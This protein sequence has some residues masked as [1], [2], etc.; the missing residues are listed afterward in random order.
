MTPMPAPIR[1]AGD[2][3]RR[4]GLRSARRKDGDGDGV[5][6]DKDRC[7]ST[8]S[9]VEVDAEGCQVLF[10]PTKKTL[11]LEGVNFETGKS[12]LTPESEAILN[13]VAESLVANDSIR[14]QVTGHTDNTGSLATQPAAL[15]RPGRRG[16]DLPHL[17]GRG[18]G[19][20][21]GPRLRPGPADR[22]QQDV[23]GQGAEPAGGV[24]QAQLDIGDRYQR[25]K[26]KEKGSAGTSK[27]RVPPFPSR[28]A[29]A[30][31]LFLAYSPFGILVPAGRQPLLRRGQLLGGDLRVLLFQVLRPVHPDQLEEVGDRQRPDEQAEQAEVAQAQERADDGDERMDLGPA[32]EDDRPDH[33]VHVATTIRMPQSASPIAAP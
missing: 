11:I 22:L 32:A 25:R 31:T 8:P 16:A 33:V 14:V 3:G 1:P 27:F 26:S 30:F 24:D 13:G 9:G 6:D 15:P 18:G 17:Q 4:Q 29:S 7:P 20:A 28:H 10:Q 21:D 5:N 2:A 12:T 19:P 23:G